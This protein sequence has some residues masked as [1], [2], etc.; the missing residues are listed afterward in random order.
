MSQAGPAPP[1]DATIAETRQTY[2]LIAAEFAERTS[3]PEPVI[4]QRLSHLASALP[5]GGL[6][7]DVGCGPGRDAILLR[8]RGFRVVGLDLSIGQLRAG[9]LP[10]LVQADM[11]RLPLRAASVDAIWCQAALLHLPRALVPGVLA[12]FGRAVR[13]GGALSLSV[14]E[15]DGEGFE[16]ASNYGS[17]RRRW[18]TFPPCARADL[19]GG[20]GRIHGAANL[21]PPLSPG[22]AV[23][24]RHP[25]L[26]EMRA[27]PRL[28]PGMVTRRSPRL[29]RRC[30]LR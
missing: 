22:L 8:E 7:A 30:Q 15:G 27:D 3:S 29:T 4:V 20:S 28:D 21:P 24:R 23:S 5:A 14:A 9:S 13:R 6:V 25:I 12:D 16:V 19:P 18:F 17:D 1:D 2:D 26:S 10:C 11:R